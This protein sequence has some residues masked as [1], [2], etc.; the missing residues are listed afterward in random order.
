ML[1]LLAG[2]RFSDRDGAR[3]SAMPRRHSEH[4]PPPTAAR[5]ATALSRCVARAEAKPL[6]T[7]E[8][9]LT[10]EKNS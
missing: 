2:R 5:R 10:K 3:P 6:R 7:A 8:R 4:M 9:K 1:A